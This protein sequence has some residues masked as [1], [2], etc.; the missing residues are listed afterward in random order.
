MQKLGMN[1]AIYSKKP[2]EKPNGLCSFFKAAEL[3]SEQMD[4][5]HSFEER[6]EEYVIVAYSNPLQA[7]GK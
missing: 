3:H 5:L 7:L 6:S 1:I 4:V 2:A